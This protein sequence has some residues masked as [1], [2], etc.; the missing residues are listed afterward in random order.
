VIS[1]ER[2]SGLYQTKVVRAAPVGRMPASPVLEDQLDALLHAD[3][4][5][6]MKERQLTGTAYR[7]KR[8]MI[9]IVAEDMRDSEEEHMIF[10]YAQRFNRG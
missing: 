4:Q 6:I 5:Q 9:S 2:E 1:R 10:E 3:I 8:R 7:D